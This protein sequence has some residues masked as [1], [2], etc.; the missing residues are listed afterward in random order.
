MDD[1]EH[2]TRGFW[3][4]SPGSVYPLLD[5][6]ARDGV[7]KRGE[8]GRYSLVGPASP[9]R[10]WGLGR[11]SPRNVEEAIVELRGLVAY[12][13]DLKLGRAGE[14]EHGLAAMREIASRLTRLAE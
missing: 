6:M 14:F 5:E 2:V 4:P 3:R 11:P 9:G 7:I 13:E 12:L 1:I 8:D 10:S